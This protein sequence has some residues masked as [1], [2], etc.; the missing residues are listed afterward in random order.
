LT[1]VEVAD[2]DVDFHI[3]IWGSSLFGLCLSFLST[4]TQPKRADILICILCSFYDQRIKINILFNAA[5]A[6][7]AK[8]V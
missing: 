5:V 6:T 1:V 8:T 7:A 4:C 3:I 2:V